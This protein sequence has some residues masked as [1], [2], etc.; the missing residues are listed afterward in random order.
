MFTYLAIEIYGYKLKVWQ[1][2]DSSEIV[3][4][5]EASGY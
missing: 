3:R 4:L 2:I 1:K 5:D